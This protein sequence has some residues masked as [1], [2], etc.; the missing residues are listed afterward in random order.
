[1]EY[2]AEDV[3]VLDGKLTLRLPQQVLVVTLPDTE[4]GSSVSGAGVTL[5]VREL[6]RDRLVLD[7]SGATTRLVS[8]EAYSADGEALAI[9]DAELARVGSVTEL[10]CSIHG[11]PARLDVQLSRGSS[12]FEYAFALRLPGPVPAAPQP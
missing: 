7:V 8:V 2:A 4:P 12:R 1:M 11:R 5:R 6:A 10:R 9:E 3:A